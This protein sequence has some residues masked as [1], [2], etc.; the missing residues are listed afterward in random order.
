MCA[1]NILLDMGAIHYIVI[2][3]LG[4]TPLNKTDSPLSGSHRWA[5]PI[6]LEEGSMKKALP[7]MLKLTGLIIYLC[8]C[9]KQEYT[10]F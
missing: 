10:C 9:I 7:P 4:A 3:L 1:V 5:I 8:S 2:D 6:Q